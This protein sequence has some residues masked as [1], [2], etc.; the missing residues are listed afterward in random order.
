MPAVRK[1]S[2]HRDVDVYTRSAV[3]FYSRSL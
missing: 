2:D 3:Y 1:A